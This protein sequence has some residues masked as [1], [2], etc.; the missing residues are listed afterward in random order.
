[1]VY[2]WDNYAQA[3]I[4]SYNYFKEQNVLYEVER[5]LAKNIVAID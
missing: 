2:R 1:M 4:T 5:I 3:Q